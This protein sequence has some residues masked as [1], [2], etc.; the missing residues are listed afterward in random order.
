MR[1]FV[2]L[3]PTL[4]F[5]SVFT[6]APKTVERINPTQTTGQIFSFHT[7]IA[8]AK[9]AVVNISTKK[10]TSQQQA[11]SP[12]MNDPFFREF[13][14][15]GFGA[16]PQER[17][18][19]SLG[20]GVIISSDGYII[21]NNHVIDKADEIVI[22]LPNSTQEYKAK[23]IGADAKS[24]LA[25]VKIEAKNLKALALA[26]SESL[27]VGDVVFA[28]GN[29]FGIGETVTQGIISALGRSGVGINEYENFIQTDA[30]INPGN[31]GGALID[32]R[33][34][35]IGINTAI[36]SRSGGN[37]GIGFAI[38]ANMVRDV[39]D[40]LASDGSVKHGLLGI[41]IENIRQELQP[42]YEGHQGAVINQI[43]P[44][45]AAE[46]AKLQLG[47]LITHVDGQAITN[48]AQLK[49]A[50]GNRKPKSTVT[51]TI[52]R[53]KKVL[54][55]KATLQEKEESVS[56]NELGLNLE[57][58]T[59]QLRQRYGLPNGINGACVTHVAPNTPAAQTGLREGDVI[60]QVEDIRLSNAASF[61]E[62]MKKYAKLP[63][64][65][66]YV[67]RDGYNHLAVIANP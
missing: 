25:L 33:G 34:A 31:S 15:Q 35:L 20:S 67:Y 47:D 32:S 3:L 49:N 51:L 27:L 4:M 59:P 55:V 19:R 57:S 52:V 64:K 13:F 12:F 8:Y 43:Y 26:D 28:I 1:I 44:N 61:D 6:Q 10:V 66:L 38:P 39:I 60:I 45:S 42:F 58:I 14:G 2:L 22:T 9:E 62:A 53:D 23:L 29:P 7:S 56:T 37:N 21:T 63:Q 48:A 16:I 40:A 30:S 54:T 41:G 46:K 11:L 18:E 24:D 50:I 36:I 65:R 5:A 17:V